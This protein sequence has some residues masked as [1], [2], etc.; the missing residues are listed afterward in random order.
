MLSTELDRCG[1]GSDYR[2]GAAAFDFRINAQNVN[3]QATLDSQHS[4]AANTIRGSLTGSL[5]IAGQGKGLDQVKPTMRGTGRARMEN[6]KLVGVNVVAQALNKVNNVPSIGVLVPA[7][8]VANHPELFR[9]P[10]TD[11]QEASL[12]FVILGP[13]I[14]SHDIVA[15]S[16]D[17]SIFADG[18]F[19]LRQGS[20]SRRQDCNVAAVQQRT[21]RRSP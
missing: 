21:G 12:T 9:S 3:V 15:H 11:I 17:Y 4:K 5:Q 2:G 19:D 18:W 8:V 20:R 6:G 10:D 7:A 14:I 1:G 16:T 13:R